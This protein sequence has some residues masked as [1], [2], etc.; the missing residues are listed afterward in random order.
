MGDV[1]AWVEAL[2]AFYGQYGYPVVFLGALAENTALLGLVL[3][4]GTLALLGGV[5][6]REGT[7]SL[8][9]VIAFAWIGTTLGYSLDYAAGRFVL[10]R[11]AGAWG[12]SRLGRRLRLAG[13]LRLARAFL[14]KHGG[15]AILLSHAVGHVRSFVALTA[16]LSGMRFA[17]FVAFELVAALLWSAAYCL[18]GYAV[19]AEWDRVQPLVERAGWALAAAL[20]VV[21]ALWRLIGGRRARQRAAARARARARRQSAA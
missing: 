20:L 19:A 3:P 17:R 4:G 9:A 6:A 5:Y 14:W 10:G 8:A 11:Y 21:Y 2:R 12:A 1:Q 15:K 7:L 13:R 18:L 16:G